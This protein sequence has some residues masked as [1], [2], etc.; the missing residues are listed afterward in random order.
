MHA[1]LSVYHHSS[2]VN[3]LSHFFRIRKNRQFLKA[4]ICHVYEDMTLPLIIHSQTNKPCDTQTHT[5][6]NTCTQPPHIQHSDINRLTE[7]S[8]TCY[9]AMFF[10]QSDA[11]GSGSISDFF[12]LQSVIL[13]FLTFLDGATF[14]RDECTIAGGMRSPPL[15]TSQHVPF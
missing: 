12:Y 5:C 13:D 15:S 2:R 9:W 10:L 8:H 6:T 14:S 1:Y 11:R 3:S 4:L 7:H